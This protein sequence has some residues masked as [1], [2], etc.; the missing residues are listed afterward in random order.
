MKK[1]L[2][3]MLAVG[4]LLSTV[5][6]TKTVGTNLMENV[7]PQNVNNLPSVD[8]GAAAAADFG[9]RLFQTAL[10]DDKNTLISPLSVLYA[11][12]M[13]ANGAD[14]ETRKQMEEVLGMD[15]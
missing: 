14:G 6:C 2:A 4:I 15:I 1:I 13:T 11:L 10:E 7:T 9:V 12:S 5:G 3:I 8:N